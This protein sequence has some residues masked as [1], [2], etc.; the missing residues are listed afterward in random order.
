MI[1]NLD[2]KTS[3]TIGI[4][5]KT[6]IKSTLGVTMVLVHYGTQCISDDVE[7]PNFPL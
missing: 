3:L 7:K 4:M 5:V 6:S 2:Y 1:E